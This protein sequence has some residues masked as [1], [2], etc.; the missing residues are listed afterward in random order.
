LPIL[1]T[2]HRE[3]KFVYRQQN[4]DIRHT[5]YYSPYDALVARNTLVCPYCV[6]LVLCETEPS[7]PI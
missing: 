5:S 3:D 4:T 2:M 7:D 1:L 6:F